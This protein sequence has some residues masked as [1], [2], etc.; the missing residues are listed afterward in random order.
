MNSDKNIVCVIPARSGSKGIKNKNL[1]D[2][3]GEPLIA[4][5]IK[6]AKQSG[7]ADHLFVSTDSEEIAD[8]ALKYGANVPFIR[9]KD[10]ASDSVHAIHVVLHLLDWLDQQGTEPPEGILMLLPT[11]PFRRPYDIR[12]A[13]E[14][15]RDHDAVSVIGVSDTGKYLTNLRF[16]KENKLEIFDLSQDRN[17]QRQ[18]LNKI[19]A[20]NGAMFLAR[21]NSLRE[22][23]TF[24]IDGAIPYVMPVINSIDINSP[25]DLALARQFC[26]VLDVW[27]VEN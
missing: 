26:E 4:W 12:K 10:L 13:V 14:V 11:S 1:I 25:H 21:P 9:P 23:K 22:N 8:I 24:H 20:V 6:A 15:F 27:S 19:Y 2:L 3:K 18:N 16:I 17:A 5:S 7:V